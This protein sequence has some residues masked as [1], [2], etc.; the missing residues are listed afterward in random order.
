MNEHKCL[1]VCS[2]VGSTGFWRSCVNGLFEGV[3]GVI[4]DLS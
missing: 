3:R 2:P 4:V 1:A